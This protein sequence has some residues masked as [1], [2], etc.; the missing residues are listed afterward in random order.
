MSRTDALLRSYAR[1]VS[2]P[3]DRALPGAQRIWFAVYHETDERRMRL[4][5][6]S[7]EI[8]TRK[9]GHDWHLRDLTNAFASWMAQQEYREAYFE[10]PEDLP[11]PHPAFGQYVVGQIRSALETSD[12]NTVVAVVGVG[13]LFGFLKVSVLMNHI[14]GA[15]EGRLL[16][17]FPGEYENNNYRLLDARDGWNYHAVPITA[18]GG[19][20][21]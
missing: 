16:V 4:R 20:P 2:L 7:F 9:A 21:E 19:L 3:W 5:L 18:S 6:P 13:S 11:N 17:F 15:I 10:S 1:Y 8:E 14:E 12:E